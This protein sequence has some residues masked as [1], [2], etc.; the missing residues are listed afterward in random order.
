MIQ[1]KK[2]I[3]AIS[4]L[5]L[6][7]STSCEK[8][9]SVS[10]ESEVKYDDHFSAKS[11]FK[12]QLTGIYTALC[13]EALYGANL[14]YGMVDALGQH[15]V[16]TQAWGKYYYF[17]RFEYDN[18]VSVGVIE[19]VWSALY[20]TVANVNILLAGLEDHPSALSP[21]ERDILKGEALAL[22][23]FLHFD[24]LRL[25]GKS[26]SSGA[27]E[28]AVPYVRT[29]SKEVTP[30]STVSEVLDLVIGDLKAA[31]ELLSADPIR[32]GEPSTPFLG[33][34]AFHFNYYAAQALLARAYLYKNDH[35]NALLYA[36]RVIESGKF[37]WVQRD[38]I[39][40]P[41]RE[42]RDGIFVTE[43]IFMLNNTKLD[44][45]SGKF[46][47]QGL[48]ED[49]SNYLFSSANVLNSIYETDRFGGVDWR[50]TYYF[51]PEGVNYASSRLWQFRT[52]PTAY[53]NRQPVLGISEMYLIAAETSPSKSDALS[54]FNTLRWHRGFGEGADLPGTI[55][56]EA[57]ANE[58][59]KEYR[60]E[61]FGEGQWF[62]YAKRTDQATLPNV[63]VPFD[64]VFYVLP[65]PDQEKDYGNRN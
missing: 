50:F 12:D 22:R 19:E 23:A 11:G 48:S 35:P 59:A 21:E 40:T 8:W 55:S 53:R 15:Y 52:M 27:N 5:L 30:L 25:F 54:Y 56:D 37:P 1:M 7:M 26:Y 44:E 4:V 20:N 31:E 9:L 13:S 36:K 42:A 16:W 45:L 29:I 14:S 61:F 58:I 38:H 3:G 39:T 28:D 33:T 65:L 63:I 24:A 32:T 62:F 57:F 51:E 6:L 34:R 2:I 18:T 64:R 41:T 49:V 46:L 60:K 47:R 10:P 17:N 43:R